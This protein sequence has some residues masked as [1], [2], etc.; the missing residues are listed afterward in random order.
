MSTRVLSKVPA[1]AAPPDPTLVDAYLRTIAQAYGVTHPDL[2]V[3][4]EEPASTSGPS[5][6]VPADISLASTASFATAR[7]PSP[8]PP[9]Q[10]SHEAIAAKGSGAQAGDV[11]PARAAEKDEY[12]ASDLLARESSSLRRRDLRIR[13]SPTDLRH[14]KSDEPSMYMCMRW[15]P[16]CGVRAN[17]QIVR[18]GRCETE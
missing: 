10:S 8:R 15:L 12:Q 6:D 14:S 13:L 3:S 9:R 11:A 4:A 16:A 17:M 18:Y 7:E 5:A 1:T 2:E